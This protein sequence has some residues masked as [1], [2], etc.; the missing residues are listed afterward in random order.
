MELIVL[1]SLYREENWNSERW[2]HAY[3]ARESISR[4]DTLTQIFKRQLPFIQ[5]DNLKSFSV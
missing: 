5:P 1:L 3:K 4:A 2:N